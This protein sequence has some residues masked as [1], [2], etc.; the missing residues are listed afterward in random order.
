M[1]FPK[2]NRAAVW[3]Y[4]L[5]AVGLLS[6]DAVVDATFDDDQ[7]DFDYYWYYYDDNAGVG[8]DDR[9]QIDSSL[10]PSVI[11]VKYTERPRYAFGDSNDTWL[12]KEYVF[13]TTEHKSKKCATMPF[14]FGE[15]WE[16][17]YCT[18]GKACADRRDRSGKGKASC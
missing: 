16:A 18:G 9:P 12:V 1:Y 15:P 6:A 17:G 11:N 10:Q 14:T 13:E 2:G 3:C 4:I 7:N 8:P 5:A